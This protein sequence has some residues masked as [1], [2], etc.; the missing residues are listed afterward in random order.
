M[1]NFPEA[2]EKRERR[3]KESERAKGKVAVWG[4]AAGEGWSTSIIR[5]RT[6][7]INIIRRSRTPAVLRRS[8]NSQR[9]Q[10]ASCL[11]ILARGRAEN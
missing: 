4:V 2:R 3:G 1:F 9:V 7:R 6:S 5:L 8:W 11:A 10:F